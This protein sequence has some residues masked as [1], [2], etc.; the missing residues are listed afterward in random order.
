MIEINSRLE[1]DYVVSR[2]HQ[3]LL[4]WK[5]YIMP[6]EL[7]LLIQ[8][9]YFGAADFQK[10]NQKF[11]RWVWE[12]SIHNCAETGLPL[13]TYSSVYISHIISRGSDRR[14]AIDPRNVNILS[15]QIHALWDSENK[16]QKQKLNIYRENQLI[17]NLLKKDYDQSNNFR[18]INIDPISSICIR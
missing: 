18:T 15:P 16:S 17:I 4:D 11:Y 5:K 1:Y 14:M 2:G 13:P 3:P 10:E 8:D 12:H 7:R 9:E 6:I